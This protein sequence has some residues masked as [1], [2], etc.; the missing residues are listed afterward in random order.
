MF[1]LVS[2][3]NQGVLISIFFSFLVVFIQL[4][5]IILMTRSF[6]ITTVSL[7][8]FHW[9]RQTH[10]ISV[11]LI[12]PISLVKTK[13]RYI[14]EI[15][16][17]NKIDGNNLCK[18]KSWNL[19][20]TFSWIKFKICGGYYLTIIGEISKWSRLKNQIFYS[21][22][23]WKKMANFVYFHNLPPFSSEGDYDSCAYSIK[24]FTIFPIWWL[25]LLLRSNNRI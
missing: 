3:I 19:K 23:F 21:K 18:Y 24:P 17:R 22:L 15:F 12:L 9:S 13:S 8:M 4:Y 10:V 6:A 11:S 7:T 16:I 14:P 5:I 20:E 2:S 25:P 1:C